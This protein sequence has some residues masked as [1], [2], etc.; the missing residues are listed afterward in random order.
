MLTST[1]AVEDLRAASSSSNLFTMELIGHQDG[2]CALPLVDEP[3]AGYRL[4]MHLH[5]PSVR[6]DTCV[7]AMS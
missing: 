3:T 1:F 4:E 5:T 6:A 7:N 2:G